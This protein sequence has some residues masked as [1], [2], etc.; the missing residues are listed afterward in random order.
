VKPSY[1]FELGS[2]LSGRNFASV[3]ANA[4]FLSLYTTKA[5]PSSSAFIGFLMSLVQKV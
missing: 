4:D 1:N 5:E 3:N 2:Y